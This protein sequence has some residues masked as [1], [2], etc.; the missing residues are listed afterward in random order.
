[1]HAVLG[2]VVCGMLMFH[3]IIQVTCSVKVLQLMLRAFAKS[4]FTLFCDVQLN[5][6][7]FRCQRPTFPGSDAL[8]P[9]SR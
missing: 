3:C 9:L 4:P 6:K 2:M 7:Y 8:L 5:I 1:M